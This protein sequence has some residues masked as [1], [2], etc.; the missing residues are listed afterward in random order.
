M[1]FLGVA[2]LLEYWRVVLGGMEARYFIYPLQTVACGGVLAWYRRDYDLGKYRRLYL[3]LAAGLLSLAIWVAP[4]WLLH[5][6][7]RMEG[8]DPDLFRGQPPLYWAELAFRFGRLVLVAPALEEI[9][10]RGFLLR[11]FIDEDFLR[12]PF[13]TYARLANCAV[14]LGFMFE[15]T[16]ADWPAALAT[17]F[18]YNLVAF[19]TRSLRCCILAHAVTNGLL[20]AYI[21]ATHQWGFW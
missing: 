20:G 9:F 15:H 1:F 16:P 19:Q 6:P 3:A 17:G 11:Y 4:Q 12:V 14:A 2:G 8:F 5:R 21:M 13:G 7:A 10:W 18:L